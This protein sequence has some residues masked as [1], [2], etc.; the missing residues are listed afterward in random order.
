M[1]GKYLTIN[2]SVPYEASTSYYS[3]IL[4]LITILYALMI[5]VGL[6]GKS[7]VELVGRNTFE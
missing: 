7:S 1:S 6:C 3:L 4:G 5:T 2:D